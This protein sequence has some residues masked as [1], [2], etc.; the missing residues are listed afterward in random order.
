MKAL[1]TF[2]VF[3]ACLLAAPT[4]SAHVRVDAPNGGEV[5]QGQSIFIIQWVDT[6]FHGTGVTYEIEL[7]T[8]GGTTW[9]QVVDNLPYTGGT[10]SHAWLVPDL[11]TCRARIRVTMHVNPT[12]RYSDTSDADFCIE[13]SYWSYGSGT[14]VGGVEPILEAHA[15]PVAGQSITLHLSQAEVGAVAHF[16]AG[17]SRTSIQRFG[18]TLLT[19]PTLAQVDQ[20]VDVNG[21]VIL[22]ASLPAAIVGWTVDV[23][24]IVESTPA[25]SASA[26]VEFQVLP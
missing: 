25:N 19:L 21:E 16:L 26:G 1:R 7:S 20:V 13:A 18:V 14:P 24:V 22:P 8:D 2:G 11:D 3:S 15:V 10:S 5:L 9:Q 6:V 4:L 12:T 17:S 23:Q